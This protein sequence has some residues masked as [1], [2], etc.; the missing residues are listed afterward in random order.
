MF[1]CFPLQLSFVV[2]LL[3]LLSTDYCCCAR[4]CFPPKTQISPAENLWEL[5][6]TSRVYRS[7]RCCRIKI[8]LSPSSPGV[9][10]TDNLRKT[11][12]RAV[13]FRTLN[14]ACLGF[15][16]GNLPTIK[17]YIQPFTKTI[18]HFQKTPLNPQHLGF[19][20]NIAGAFSVRSET[21]SLNVNLKFSS[22]RWKQRRLRCFALYRHTHKMKRNKFRRCRTTSFTNAPFSWDGRQI[23]RV[24]SVTS[25]Q[26][27]AFLWQ[28]HKRALCNEQ[29]VLLHTFY[30]N[31][32][33]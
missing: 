22:R 25:A 7:S 18:H 8:L 4:D 33:S 2:L 24:R 1:V 5:F 28:N 32:R 31:P 15:S 10:W 23:I 3:R 17:I 20:A 30:L 21:E 14:L 29:K 26:S 16:L 13:K 27:L 19:H 12:S 11:C 9:L 6:P